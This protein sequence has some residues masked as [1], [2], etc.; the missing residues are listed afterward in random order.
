[1][2]FLEVFDM[3]SNHVTLW[4]RIV[5]LLFFIAALLFLSYAM[6]DLTYREGYVFMLIILTTI[7][8][9]AGIWTA[10]RPFTKEDKN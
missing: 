4:D 9:W 2:S 5:G 1:M 6:D 3:L 8:G 10:T 7:V